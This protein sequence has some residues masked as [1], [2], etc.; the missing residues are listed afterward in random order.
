MFNLF[1]LPIYFGAG[2]LAA[3]ADRSFGLYWAW[4]REIPFVPWMIWPY[5]SL[6]VLFQLPLFQMSAGQ[7]AALSRQS[8]ATLL[9]A[10]AFFLLVPTH[11]G[12]APA[13]VPAFY[14]SL[15]ELLAALDTPHNL[16]PSLHVAFSALILLGCA[17][18]TSSRLAW[19]YRGWLLLLSLSTLLVHQHHLFDVASGLLLA[20]VMRRL[21]PTGT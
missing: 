8:T 20:L 7:I 2:Y 18:R 14:R 13:A 1:F 10:G 9:A 3:R 12:F 19:C 21:F 6:F 4:E 11:A 17:S 16:A 15:F 5:L